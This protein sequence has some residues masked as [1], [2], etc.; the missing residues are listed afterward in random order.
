MYSYLFFDLDGTLTDPAPGIT[1]SFIHAY[2]TFGMEVPS[3]EQLCTYI[4][5]PLRYTFEKQF[6]FS[7]NKID[8]GVKIYREYYSEKGL[9]ENSVFPGI[10]D[11]LKKL[12]N[13]GVNLSVATSKPE[14]F[15]IK[16]LEKFGIAQYFD[17]ICGSNMDETRSKKSE[18]IAYALERNGNPDPKTVLMIGDRFHDVEGAKENGIKCAGVL[19]GYGDKEELEKAGADYLCSSV[20]ELSELCLL[21][22]AR[23]AK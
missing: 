19:F 14:H 6:G 23:L 10:E 17:F 2:K 12:K 9:F 15:T 13:Q 18:V 16:S 5:P 1:N 21:N 4:G 3:Y 22:T 20:E 11:M 8:E 7:G